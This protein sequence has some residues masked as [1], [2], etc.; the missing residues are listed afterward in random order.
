[1]NPLINIYFSELRGEV[2]LATTAINFADIYYEQDDG[3][4]A[5]PMDVNT[6]QLG[7][8][9]QTGLSRF[10]RADR[11]L[12]TA[13]KTE[14]PAFLASCAKTVRAFEKSTIY[15]GVCRMPNEFRF[16]ACRYGKQETALKLLLPLDVPAT[17]I[18][19]YAFEV[20]L[21]VRNRRH[22]TA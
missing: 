8:A 17:R 22:G 12:R 16:S 3:A 10:I 7:T 18:G 13:K 2:I 14:W 20:F 9:I 5:Y 1:M 15:V 6:E 11:N 4:I 21:Q 19:Q